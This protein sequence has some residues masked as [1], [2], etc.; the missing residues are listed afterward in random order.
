MLELQHYNIYKPNEKDQRC[1]VGKVELPLSA[2]IRVEVIAYLIN[3]KS[4]HLYPFI[5]MSR[6]NLIST[7]EHTITINSKVLEY[8]QVGLTG[9]YGNSSIYISTSAGTV[10]YHLTVSHNTETILFTFERIFSCVPVATL[11][12]ENLIFTVYAD[13]FDIPMDPVELV[14]RATPEPATLADPVI[15]LVT[16]RPKTASMSRKTVNK[17]R[18]IVSS[19][20]EDSDADPD[21]SADPSSGGES[22]EPT[23]YTKPVAKGTGR[24]ATGRGRGR[25]RGATGRGRGRGATGRG[26]G[27]AE[28]MGVMNVVGVKHDK[29]HSDAKSFRARAN[30]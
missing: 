15:D 30:M 5:S 2:D 24:G 26:N 9:F 14:K 20:E 6:P 29:G 19:D 11:A 4:F 25:G 27:P 28:T 7:D 23:K 1:T 8:A 12:Y 3:T 10:N 22:D 17:L 16:K 18:K 21:P 13:T